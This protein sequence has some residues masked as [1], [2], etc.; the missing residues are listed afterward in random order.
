[1]AGEALL[2]TNV[3]IPFL[4]NE[5]GISKRLSTTFEEVFISAIVVGELIYGAMCS[6]RVDENLARVEELVAEVATLSLDGGTAYQY[7]KLKQLLRAKGKPI[8]EN[9]IWLAASGIQY[10][11]TLVTKDRHFEGVDGL[12]VQI[13]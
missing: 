6:T 13:W 3:I 4:N 10:G 9:D 12:H 1:M 8:P 11:L 7:G 5:D 2:D